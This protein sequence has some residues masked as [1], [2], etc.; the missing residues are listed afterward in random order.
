M[1]LL[2]LFSCQKDIP[3]PRFT[4]IIE[5][6]VLVIDLNLLPL[7]LPQLEDI[8]SVFQQYILVSAYQVNGQDGK[9]LTNFYLF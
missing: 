1:L 4:S 7:T 8:P 3:F 5:T 6:F 2:A 9:I